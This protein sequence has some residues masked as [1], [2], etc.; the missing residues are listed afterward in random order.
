MRR[1]LALLIGLL[2]L[3][4]AACGDDDGDTAATDTTAGEEAAG[5]GGGDT[6]E[7]TRLELGYVPYADAAPTFLAIENGI[8]EEHGLEVNVTPAQ[9][10][11]QIV[12]TMAAGET[13]IGFVTTPVLVNANAQGTKIKCVTAVAG[14]QA[15]DV[16]HDATGLVANPDSGIDSVADLAGKRVGVVQLASLN[17]LSIQALLQEEGVDP[18]AAELVQLPFPQMPDALQ[19]GRVDAAIIVSPF[20]Q[21]ALA[22]GAKLVTHPNV[23]LWGDGTPVCFSATDT[24]I[25][26]NEDVLQRFSDAMAEAIEYSGDNED[27]AKATLTKYMELTEEQA[28]NQIISSTFNPALN[29]ETVEKTIDIMRSLGALQQDLKAEDLVW[30]GART[31]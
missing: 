9:A 11:T 10:P 8:F 2:A 14:R 25:E 26:E 6:A 5:D 18:A 3:V 17:S 30:D 21:G 16:D 31:E 19:Q 24:F 1:T 4:A 27:E 12:A 15:T 13:D 23:D 20:L 28:Q 29:V 22:N 7:L